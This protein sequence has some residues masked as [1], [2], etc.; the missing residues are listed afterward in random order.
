MKDEDKTKEQLLEE[1]SDSRR[2]LFE[3][4]Q[5]QAASNKLAEDLHDAAEIMRLTVDSLPVLLSYIDSQH[6]YRFANRTYQHWFNFPFE[7][8]EG[9]HVKDVLGDTLY[10]RLR[11]YHE[12][13]FSGKE[14]AFEFSSTHTDGTTR[15][16]N[17]VYVPHFAAEGE[18]KGIAVLVT[19]ITARKVA[20]RALEKAR[21]E[22]ERRVEERTAELTKANE[23]LK[24]EIT[25]RKKS[26]KALRES[27]RGL[28]LALRGAD[29][30]LWDLR[31]QT[32][33]VFVSQRGAEMLGYSLNEIQPSTGF[34]ANLVH[35]EDRQR[36]AETSEAHLSGRTDYY[37]DEYRIR[38]KSGD[39]R[40]I[41]ARGQVVERDKDG[42]PLRMAGTFLDISD[43]KHA[44]E[45]LRLSE[46]RYRTVAD[47][48]FD[49]EYWAD[50]DGKLLYVSPACE[51]ITGYSAQEIVDEPRLIHKII[52]PDDHF[53]V[54]EHFLEMRQS[55]HDT[56]HSL[57]FRIIHRNGDTRWI[58]HCCRPV[59]GKEGR[60]LG[61]R[62]CNRDITDRKM[63]E[64]AILESEARYRALFENMKNGVAIYA[65][66]ENGE[67]FI[68]LDFNKAAEV[69]AS[70]PGTDVIGRRLSET[71]PAAKELG[72]FDALR[73]TWRTGEPSHVPVGRYRDPRIEIWV[74]NFV[75][76]L[77]SGEIVA[78]FSDETKRMK[79]EEAQ[80]RLA[81][82]VEQAAEAIIVTDTDGNVQYVNPAFERVAGFS[83]D[84]VLGR[85][86]SIL[87]SGEHSPL[88]YKNL[89][90]TIKRGEVWSGR[91]INKKKD[92][93]LYHEEATIT[94]V[95]DATGQ[96]TNYVAVKRDI[97]KHLELSRQLLQAQK[98]EAVGTLAGG[99]AHDFNNLLQAVLGYS[100]LILMD[101][102]LDPRFKDDLNKIN[103]SAANGADL[104]HRLLTFSRKTEMKLRPLNL[105]HQI[106]QVRKLLSRTLPKMIEIEVAFAP[107][108]QTINADPTQVEQILMNLAVN[109]KD[110]MPDGGK[111]II[112]TG[113]VSLDDL[114]C[115]TRLGATAGDYVMLTVSDTGQGMDQET[116]EHIFE[117]FYTTKDVG[118][119]TGLGLAIVYGI[120][121]QH[122][123]YIECQSVPGTGTTFRV[124]FPA[125]RFEAEDREAPLN[126]IP[127]GGTETILLVDDEEFV[128]DLGKRLLS[129]AGYTVLT[130][131]TGNEALE[132]YGAER[133][134]IS[135][136]ILD[137]IMPEMGGKQCLEGLLKIDPGT[138][139]LIAS[140]YSA[141][142]AIKEALA[143]LVKG[144]VSKPYDMRQILQLVRAAL[145][146]N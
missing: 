66:E 129:K 141:D 87:K 8:L 58:N 71:F 12:S 82:A 20:E 22:L 3:L 131:A 56:P 49:W 115:R 44:E 42:K 5:T 63:A 74:E 16:V 97:T 130:A 4:Q 39:W 30:G 37:E 76:K 127:Q 85:N 40:W 78:V 79:R 43:R 83:R 105:N 28:E 122:D 73:R 102:D 59:H 95:R 47:F 32:G 57:D 117:P 72:L 51:R 124:Y 98:M 69:I 113:N 54:M 19:D 146:N 6:R 110:A 14:T 35:P 137:L 31:F 142:A 77:P 133:G 112:Q 94:P 34:W 9:K 128:R 70:V 135:L 111:L 92:G 116:R 139:V 18:V 89:W 36:A 45:D 118:R 144:F 136:V 80:R 53:M 60:P 121:K 64:E 15:D 23:E 81:T 24:R 17:V 88:F 86:P 93:S 109:A 99:I 123:G 13:A 125:L 138:R 21:E 134:R 84:E 132:V 114:F 119:G 65:A 108:L 126:G 33:E 120:V 2:Q 100:E 61:R 91:F 140:G 27:E 107:N 96:I 41:L 104:V 62:A 143:G 90:D 7:K 26:E 38:H 10:E 50:P 48:T 52:H 145:D 25:E 103:Q 55:N 29:L 46:E 67:D 68:L 101:E 75:Y 106:D 11:P 1:L